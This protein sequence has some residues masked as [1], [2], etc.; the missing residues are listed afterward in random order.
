MVCTI[1]SHTKFLPV[2]PRNRFRST[3]MG[4]WPGRSTPVL[5]S[6]PLA[7]RINSPCPHAGR[8]VN[9]RIS[10]LNSMVCCLRCVTAPSQYT[11]C[12]PLGLLRVVGYAR[13]ADDIAMTISSLSC[14]RPNLSP[15]P[16]N[17]E[18]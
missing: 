8:Y 12:I 5:G 7:G 13:L 15:H 10:F 4:T 18:W 2:F 17:I 6:L 3:T 11:D 14:C 1:L 16:K 9:S